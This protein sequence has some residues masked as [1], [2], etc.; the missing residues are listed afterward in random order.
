VT[1][2]TSCVNLASIS[3]LLGPVSSQGHM[4]SLKLPCVLSCDMLSC[5]CCLQ[6][7]HIDLFTNKRAVFT[8][9]VT[10]AAAAQDSSSIQL[11]PR[12][13]AEKSVNP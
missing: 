13:W 9:Q 8:S 1:C 10:A 6:V 12:E 7:D 11:H 5:C 3:A 4:I 2:G